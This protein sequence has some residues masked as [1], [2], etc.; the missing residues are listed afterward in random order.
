MLRVNLRQDGS[1]EGDAGTGRFLGGYRDITKWSRLIIRLE[2]RDIIV[3]GSGDG[4]GL[5]ELGRTPRSEFPGDPVAIRVGK[6]GP[7]SNAGDYST[8]GPTGT[9]AIKDLEVFSKIP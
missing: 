3:M 1:F 9:S 8:P 7:E 4:G 6:I 5:I 2:Q